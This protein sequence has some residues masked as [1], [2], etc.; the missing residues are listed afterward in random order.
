MSREYTGRHEYRNEKVK[1]R[2][3][4]KSFFL[5]FF[6]MFFT[7][8]AGAAVMLTLYIIDIKK[9]IPPDIDL[10]RYQPNL[11]TVIYDRNQQE[12]AR[13]YQ[14]NRTLASLK[15][16]SPWII[17]SILAAE[18]GAFYEHRGIRPTSIV[19]AALVSFRKQEIKQGGSTITQQLARNL[20]LT[21]D[22]TIRRKAREV[23]IA[24]RL[25]RIYTKDQI[26]E[27]YL[28]TIYLGHGNYGVDAASRGFFAKSPS[29]LT[30]AEASLLAGI[31]AAPE[32][33]TPLRHMEAAKRRQ[34]YVLDRMVALEFISAQEAEEA[35]N[36][37]ITFKKQKGRATFQVKDAPYF[38]SH[39][40]FKHLLPTYGAD[41]VYRGGLRI[42]TTIDLALQKKAEEVISKL[43]YEG[44]LVALDPNTGEIL[45]LVGGRN[46]DQSKFNRATQAYRQPGS[47]FKPI[48]Y[49]TAVE[50]GYRPVDRMLDA[51]LNFANGWSPKNSNMKYAGEVTLLQALVQSINTV[52]VRLTQV[53]GVDSVKNIARSMGI[54]TQYLPDDLSIALGTASVTPLE[55]A[56]A[57]SSFINNGNRVSPYGVRSISDASN[58]VIEQN[59]PVLNRAISAETAV[60]I[61]SMLTHA[62][63]WGTGTRAR[64]SGYD[65]FGKTGTTNDWTDAWFTGGVPG[66]AVVVYIGND[67]HTRLGSRK[68]GGTIAA[69]VWHEFTSFAVK[70]LKTPKKFTIPA[71]VRVELVRICRQTGY[72]AAG[73]CP[74][75][76]VLL[77]A[78]QAPTALCPW[79][80]G[81]VTLASA[82]PNAPQLILA[83]DDDA[84][85]GQYALRT[86]APA[87]SADEPATEPDTAVRRPEAPDTR[88]PERPNE[89]PYRHDPTPAAEIEQKYQDLLK[90]YNIN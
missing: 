26:L 25:E 11:T 78:G 57:Y 61:R 39:I 24:I 35:Y 58:N 10:A 85:R 81:S 13:L 33:Y 43:P 30:L 69:P 20:F 59:G 9:E 23:L 29:Q 51:P 53:V 76:E 79:H 2:S 19:R 16:V 77:P 46:F 15:D 18:D 88:A 36:T 87:K 8:A 68:F 34:R 75:V 62:V 64:I 45:A 27:M 42:H 14:E 67:D 37:E 86:T 5:F 32:A 55:M 73:G 80:G 3:F 28:N 52:V 63:N 22:Q 17:K 38:V 44:A 12:I 21:K 56:V 4:L 40:L 41:R 48:V 66:I 54:S 47:A 83:P 1:K 65:V 72:K 6:F 70:Q 7:A 90:Q 50:N 31:I 89:S 60:T 82:D 74:S 84:S 49:A 71:D